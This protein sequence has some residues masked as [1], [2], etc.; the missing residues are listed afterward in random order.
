MENKVKNHSRFNTLIYVLCAALMLQPSSCAH[1]S[2]ISTDPNMESS[3]LRCGMSG[4]CRLYIQ[5]TGFDLGYDNEVRVGTHPCVVDDYYLSEELVVC[6]MPRMLYQAESGL[7]VVMKVKGSIIECRYRDCTVNF[8]FNRTPVLWSV[9][10]QALFAGQPVNVRGYF[11]SDRLSDIKEVRISGRNCEISE[12]SMEDKMLSWWGYSS[13]Q[14]IVPDDMENGDHVLSLTS[15]D[16][17]GFDHPLRASQGF[18]VGTTT[19]TYN[20][21]VHPH[22]QKISANAGYM[23]GQILEITGTGFGDDLKDISI[24]L[25]DVP[26]VV[27][28]VENFQEKEVLPAPTTGSDEDEKAADQDSVASAEFEEVNVD[29]RTIYY[30]KVR[31]ALQARETDFTDKMF[32]G[33]AGVRNEVYEGYNREFWNLKGKIDKPLKYD[34]IALVMENM[35][36]EDHYMQRMF[37]IFKSQAAGTYTFKISGDDQTRL[38]LS[39][40]PLDFTQEFDPTTLPEAKCIIDGWTDFREFNRYD[41]QSCDYT[42]EENKEYYI[43]VFQ[44]E[45]GGGDHLTVGVTTPNDDA[46]K[47]NQSPQVQKV[48]IDY[49]P[50][51]QVI[52]LKIMNAIGG[53]FRLVFQERDS[54][55]GETTYYRETTKLDRDISAEDLSEQIRRKTG[56]ESTAKRDMLDANEK[57]TTNTNKVMG[58]IWTISFTEYRTRDM[59]PLV[60]TEDIIGDGIKTSVEEVTAQT[61]QVEGHFTLQYGNSDAVQINYNHSGNTMRDRLR[62]IDA[63][64]EGVSVYT[65][66]VSQDGREWYVSMDAITGKAEDLKVVENNLTGDDSKGKPQVKITPEHVKHSLAQQYMPIPSDFLR[67]LYTTPQITMSVGGMMA[68]CDK[69]NCSYSF[70]PKSST[71]S[72]TSF[73]LNNLEL[74]IDVASPAGRIL[75]VSTEANDKNITV[76]FGN[77]DCAVTS[78]AWPVIKC[79]MPTNPDG[80]LQIESGSFHP[81][82]HF[83][84]KGYFHVDKTAVTA[85][86]VPLAISSVS[87]TTGSTGGG[88]K[89]TISGTGFANNSSYGNTNTVTVGGSPCEIESFT[90]TQIVC[91]TPVKGS[92]GNSEISVSVNNANTTSSAFSYDDGVTPKI[93]S[94][95]PDNSSP[96]LKKDLVINGTGFSADPSRFTVWLKPEAVDG[97]E[98]ECNTV[99]STTTTIT[100]R[101]SGGKKGAYRVKVHMKGVGYSLPKTTDS[102]LFHYRTTVT[103]ISPTK[104]SLVGGTVLTIQG[105]N[106]S[107]VKNENQVVLGDSG[108]DYCIILTATPTEI[109]CRI[110][111]PKE[112]LNDNPEI[113]V[114][115]RIQEEADCL[116]TCKFLFS[117][118][119]TPTVSSISPTVAQTGNTITVNGTGFTASAD[120]TTVT[121]GGV[122][123]ANL[124]VTA[125]KLTFD[126]PALE[127]GSHEPKILVGNK[128]YAK[129]DEVIMLESELKMNSI[130]PTEG[131]KSGAIFTINGNG[132]KT[133][134][135]E[136]KIYKTVC[137]V[138]ES[139]T[140]KIVASCGYISTNNKSNLQIT[141]QDADNIDQELTCEN[142]SFTPQ[143]TRPYIKEII[144]SPPYDLSNV[145]IGV[146]GD[147][148]KTDPQ[149]ENTLYDLANLRAWLRTAEPEK[150]GN[151]AVEGTVS[152][153]ALGVNFTFP[154][155]VAGVYNIEYHIDGVGFA[156]LHSSV[157]SITLAPEV[158]SATSIESSLA[159]GAEFTLEGKGFPSTADKS[160]AMVKVCG[161]HCLV[162][163]S[164]HTSLKCKTPVLNTPEVQDSIELLSPQ[165]I[166]DAVV[167]GDRT[168]SDM[169]RIIDGDVNTYYYGDGTPDCWVK[170]DFGEDTIIRAEKIRLFPR[171]NSDETRLVGG[172]L[173][174]SN[175]DQ[176][177]TTLV[178][179]SEN[180]I[181]NWNVYK[182]ERN[183]GKWD[184]RY[185]KF[186]GGVRDCSIAEIEVTGYKFADVPNINLTGHTCDASL[187]VAGADTAADLTQKVTYKESLTPKIT[188]IS[189]EMGTTAGGTTLTISG[190]NFKSDSKVTIDGID[191]VVSSAT[192]KSIECVTGSRP[193]FTDSTLEVYS[194]TAGYAATNGIKY[195]YIDRWSSPNTWGGEAPPREGDSVHVPKGQ[196]LLVDVSPPPL[197]A[198]IVEGVIMWE[199]QPEMT[200]DAWFIMVREGQFRIGSPEKPHEGKLTITLYGTKESKQLPGFGNKSIMVHNGQIDIHGKPLTKTWTMLEKGASPDDETITVI[201]ETNWKVGDQIIIAPTGQ[202]KDEVE[203]RTIKKIDGKVITL[204]KAL[205]YHHF[206]GT[207]DPNEP[208]LK[209]GQTETINTINPP[210]RD[211]PITLRAEVGLLT[212]NV[213]VQGD[214]D[215]MRTGHGAHIMVRGQEGVARGRFSYLEVF[216]AGQKFQLG[217]YPI[218]FHMIG[219]VVDNY[220]RGCAV[221]QTFNRGTTIHG[222]HYLVLEHNVY[223]RTMGHTIFLE[224]GIETNNVIQH[225]LVVHVSKS[226]SMLMSDLKPS[227]LW[228]AR[229]SNFIRDNHFVASDNNGTWFELV[230][231]PTGPSAT[232]SICSVS[233]HLVQYDRNVHHSNGIGLRIYP[234]YFPKTNPCEA[235]TNFNLRDP[236]SEN[237]DWPAKI[238][239]NIMYMNGLGSFGKTIGAVQYYR[240]TMIS[241]SSNQKIF[242]PH[243]AKDMNAK[244]ED[245]ISIGDSELVYF[246][247]NADGNP[248][249]TNCAAM[250]MPQKSGFLVKNT[251]F[252]NFNRG[253]MFKLCTSCRNEKKRDMGGAQT[254]FEDVQFKNIS[255]EMFGFDFGLYDKDIIRDVDG[256]LL[257]VIQG[258]IP[259]DQKS[260]LSN[261]GWMTYW[262]PHMDVPECVKQT[263]RLFCN[264]DCALCSADI[265]LRRLKHTVIDDTLLLYGQDLKL[266]NLGKSGD[267]SNPNGF[268]TDMHTVQETQSATPERR[269]EEAD[270]PVKIPDDS[271]F[272]FMKFRNC[273]LSM[274]WR[275]WL[276]VVP[277]SYQYNFHFGTGVEWKEMKTENDYYWGLYGAEKP[278]YLRH[279]F[280]EPRETYEGGFEGVN[281]LPNDEYGT[282]DHTA[283]RKSSLSD[284]NSYGD[285]TIDQ[286]NQ[287]IKWKIDEKR[288]GG[289]TNKVVYCT[290]ANCNVDPV[291]SNVIEDKVRYWSDP[292]SWTTGQLPTANDNETIIEETWNMHMDVDSDFPKLKHL[293]IKG[294]LT[295]D[296]TKDNLEL[297]AFL[298]EIIQG[299]ELIVGSKDSPSDK[300]VKI[301]LF[302]Q[303]SSDYLTV[304]S[305]IAPVNKAIFNKGLLHL[306]G[307]APKT[308][309]SHLTKKV[310]VGDA[311]F[312]VDGTD[313][314]WKVGDELVV[315]S[316]TTKAEEREKVTIKDII[317]GS[318]NTEI[319]INETFKYAHYGTAGATSTP[320]GP[321]DMRAEVGNLTRN[322]KIVSDL[323]DEWG[324]TI[325][326][327]SFTPLEKNAELLQGNL[328]L[329]G[330]EIQNCGQRDTRK[331]AV[332]LNWVKKVKG[333]HTIN[334]CSFNNGQ[335]WAINLEKAQAVTISNNVIYD[336]RR[337]GI[338]L[339]KEIKAVTVERN[340]IVGIK[341]RPNYDNVEYFDTLIGIFHDDDETHWDQFE[342]ASD[343]IVMRYNSV[344]SCPWFGYAVPG[345]NCND[346][347]KESLNFVDNVAH[348]NRGGWIPTK[349]KNQECALFSHFYSYRNWEQ[350]FVQRADIQDIVVEHFILA[351]NRNGLVINGGTGQ[352]YPSVIFRE[353]AIVGKILGDFTESYTGDDCETTGMITSLFNRN[354]YD[355]YWEETRLPMHNSTNHNFSFGGSQEVYEVDFIHFKESEDCPGTKQ[356]AIRMNNFYQDNGSL[357]TFRDITLTDVDDKNRLFFP[358]H[359]KHLFTPAYCGKIDCT[360]NYNNLFI[361][362]KG[363][364]MGNNQKMHFFGNNKGAGKDGDCT[365]FEDWNGHACN[366]EYAQLLLTRQPDERG[367]NIFPLILKRENYDKDISDELKFNIE[368][369][370]PME[371]LSLIKKG[372]ET[373]VSTSQTMPSGLTYQLKTESDSDYVIIKIQSENPATMN[374]MFQQPLTQKKPRRKKPRTLRA[375][376]TL[377]MHDYKDDCGAN[378]YNAKDRILQFVVTGN[379]CKVTV[380]FANALQLSTRLNIDPDTFFDSD[381]ITTFLDRMA[382]LLE[383]SVDRIKVVDIRK[384]STIVVTEIMS[385]GDVTT[386]RDNKDKI[387]E[388]FEGF[389][390]KFEEAVA[391]NEVD[392]GAPVL[393]IDSEMAIDNVEPVPDPADDSKTDTD[394]TGTNPTT[395]E[396]EEGSNT[397]RNVLLGIFI[398]VGL[399]LIGVGVFCLVKKLRGPK[400]PAQAPSHM[401]ITKDLNSARDNQINDYVI[402]NV[403][404]QKFGAQG[405]SKIKKQVSLNPNNKLESYIKRKN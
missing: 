317:V 277:T 362:L 395:P 286:D 224:D 1:I 231:H 225:N 116:T 342:D 215:T 219:H 272:G 334:K 390:K 118:S 337:Y 326:T 370:G 164:S 405:P 4:G 94:L 349:L 229:P 92:G 123:V 175:D 294:R 393:N 392:L 193:E 133:E 374:V 305:D 38:Y 293:K 168:H 221:H 367:L 119:E 179:I 274:G 284:S 10:P 238:N 56:W 276:S 188:G 206:S 76:R 210:N 64:F 161:Q 376:Q 336:A 18:T 82:V 269:L 131:S 204:D 321:I 199:D 387:V 150:Y 6:E 386:E 195:L 78:V 58:F 202:N 302:G 128:G 256:S 329:E 181:E 273:Q 281:A 110:N 121:V 169:N 177:Y 358:N 30:Q 361:D 319:K 254:N 278:V 384:G 33:G 381:G 245:S 194:A 300:N 297:N 309:W 147:H 115:G 359:K 22:I 223:Y 143:S 91:E 265:N 352:D 65:R 176:T 127:F 353:S 303:K 260:K 285:Y 389:K 242:R 348:S 41:T 366:P 145:I 69:D 182:P 205:V 372:V 96:V 57:V 258:G 104:G 226:T 235:L 79:D 155:M 400:A 351:D 135:M 149:D 178:T 391:N 144:S 51:R 382:A 401:N 162:T 54:N 368:T 394:S 74:T 42:L 380:E 306:H 332:D 11:R 296:P 77:S 198:V 308:T 354:P 316:S 220:V 217:R 117:S 365:F 90:T 16:G 335:G 212:R 307:T 327:P 292:N 37:G 15:G 344:S 295:M 61:A 103:S 369:N 216:R 3:S 323:D 122:A 13:F 355:F 85:H 87:P 248:K 259:D 23:N 298:I 48:W 322:V 129:F 166:R 157:P 49:K 125:T 174:G 267:D 222:V 339:G 146:D 311:H 47:P 379:D 60:K 160:L 136:V 239:D 331:A 120:D 328:V 197:Y 213:K 201:D 148:L 189:P 97:K 109:T 203:E 289:F 100:C 183:G 236:Y 25:E 373:F 55:T 190:E 304:T 159:G 271:K 347:A 237:P 93:D 154:N 363:E 40:D 343:Q 62:T 214:P 19:K 24:N 398:P 356:T 140:N 211:G 241:N 282:I 21:R 364:I 171:P 310:A 134:D 31:C 156:K 52:K 208:H 7:Q 17:T 333:S 299:G 88:T 102:D 232:S 68:G 402:N 12:E 243:M 396:E 180:V 83:A 130:S 163:E 46:S 107:T 34:R 8:E 75:E 263:N 388:E 67:T 338:Y 73:T 233:D 165:V 14:C 45:G 9:D 153:T 315:A 244:I 283:T 357:I 98:Y 246:H 111:P 287:M 234:H 218:H 240:Q 151:F 39:S 397:T 192:D 227:G 139:T 404:V 313:L 288:I 114:L 403:Q 132:F 249:F 325:L 324:C 191:C 262:F 257:K 66:G 186:S 81:M 291:A 228:Q 318:T 50:T 253:T 105:T 375:G 371:V 252:Y 63:L 59:L 112:L 184:F 314:G 385:E 53:S 196:I 312:Y 275:G 89:I 301:N 268:N 270:P 266:F 101:L 137:D 5:G 158:S 250:N 185:L 99:S 95:T 20:L 80:S 264:Q 172:L 170:L 279:N 72:V 124:S 261:G 320:R 32:R 280:T 26:C 209:N 43:M 35:L 330:V 108:L 290:G 345:V 70:L 84:D 230:H 399:I 28:S 383:I 207:V 138:W 255:T 247:T 200:F 27:L 71:P 152:F 377:D 173:Q 378:Y 251:R 167:T 106:F 350:G 340:L 29:L 346:K 141:Y 2:M 360:A 126:M 187:S 86:T 113:H 44:S 142:C 341:E 36:D